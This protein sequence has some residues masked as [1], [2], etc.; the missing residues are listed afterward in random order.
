MRTA[1]RASEGPERPTI[2]AFPPLGLSIGVANQPVGQ[3]SRT[4]VDRNTLARMRIGPLSR[5]RAGVT[6]VRPATT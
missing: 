1:P 2:R 3:H 6:Y 5:S 4:E